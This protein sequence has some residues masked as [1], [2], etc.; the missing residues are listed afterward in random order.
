MAARFAYQEEYEF[1]L[2]LV[3][4]TS[5]IFIPAF[6]SNKDVQIKAFGSDLVTKTDEAIEKAI[7]SAIRKQYPSDNTIGE[8][9]SEGAIFDN[10][11]T[12]I[13]DPIDGTTNF[14]HSNPE[15]CICIGFTV[16]KTP[17]FGV[18]YC[19]ILRDLYTGRRG[20]E[21]SLNGR[22]IRVSETRALDKAVVSTY[23]IPSESMGLKESCETLQRL[24]GETEGCCRGVRL[25]GSSAAMIC[26][27]AAG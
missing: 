26:Q 8:E 16:D 5:Q 22:K 27:L 9:S 25:G 7:F 1:A 11:R 14:V 20:F 3:Q 10:R 21:A 12:W 6:H 2:R 17:E 4:Q 18:I 23:L 13:V 15:C 24:A 19:P